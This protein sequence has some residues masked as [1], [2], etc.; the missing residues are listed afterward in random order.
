MLLDAIII[1]L[2]ES[3]EAGILISLLLSISTRSEFS[4][5][6][7]LVA[8]PLGLMGAALYA[9][10]LAVISAWFDYVG[11][12]VVNAGMQYLIYLL[13]VAVAALASRKLR[14]PG[15]FTYLMTACVALAII[16]EGGEIILFYSG[17]LGAEQLMRGSLTSGFIGLMI[18][19]SIGALCYF[20]VMSLSA[21][22]A[23]K[24]Q[25]VLIILV[26][27]GMVAQ[28]T[29]LLLQADW[30]PAAVPV[31]DTSHWLSENSVTG[32]LAYAVF[33]YEASPT[34]IEVLCYLGALL[35]AASIAFTRL[36]SNVESAVSGASPR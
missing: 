2:R 22:L 5:K 29:Q 31:W 16:R 7:L 19:F 17:F 34:L 36:C 18:G 12:E 30:L 27:A 3:L 24:T 13:L 35:L 10:N 26:A 21:R 15:Y 25:I 33:G 4:P 8:I 1:V 6:W 32:Q 11:Q 14:L 9:R 23:Q 28:A 20:G